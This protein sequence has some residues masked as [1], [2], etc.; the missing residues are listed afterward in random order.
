VAQRRRA[1]DV[2]PVR[3]RDEAPGRGRPGRLA[4]AVEP[5]DGPVTAT[6]QLERPFGTPGQ[7]ERLQQL[8][9]VSEPDGT[10]PDAGPNRRRRAGSVAERR[11][12]TALRSSV[13]KA[14]LGVMAGKATTM[15]SSAPRSA[16]GGRE[17]RDV[18]GGPLSVGSLETAPSRAV[19]L[20]RPPPFGTVRATFTAHGSCRSRTRHGFQLPE[21]DLLVAIQ[22]QQHQVVRL[23]RAA[24]L[25]LLPVVAMQLF[26]VEQVV[27]T[28]GAGPALSLGQLLIRTTQVAAPC[29][30][31]SV[32]CRRS[33]LT[34][35]RRGFTCVRPTRL[36]LACGFPP[37]GTPLGRFVRALD[38]PVTRAAERT[39]D[40]P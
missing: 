38:R 22:V 26:P 35:P 20:R 17:G 11:C 12:S 15:S 23:I 8:G 25:S 32:G 36:P 14:G 40:W 9:E 10:Q 16:T 37:T 13:D 21:M 19:S 18:P 3:R 33:L 31:G 39:G 2:P 28:D 24:F 30:P 1:G 7:G 27:T 5:A 6:G 4:A 34:E 29:S